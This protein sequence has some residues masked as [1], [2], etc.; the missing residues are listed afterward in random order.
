MSR[1]DLKVRIQSGDLAEQLADALSQ[2]QLIEFIK[3]LDE[4]T[5]DWDFTNKLHTYFAEQHEAFKAEV[6]AEEDP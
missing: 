5:A 2:P 3:R 4:M 1:V 6:A